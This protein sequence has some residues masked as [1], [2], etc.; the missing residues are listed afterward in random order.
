[1][2]RGPSTAFTQVRATVG[3]RE[4]AIKWATTESGPGIG[5]YLEIIQISWLEVKT[6]IFPRDF[7]RLVLGD[8]EELAG[9]L[10]HF[11]Y[12]HLPNKTIFKAP[13]P[14]DIGFSDLI[15]SQI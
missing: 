7:G 1:M 9:V 11:P 6:S 8:Q 10:R 5:D 13:H 12:L 3:A 2:I 14:S 4:N 15:R